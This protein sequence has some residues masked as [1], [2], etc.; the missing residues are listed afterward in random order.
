MGIARS[1]QKYR[2]HGD[3]LLKKRDALETLLLNSELL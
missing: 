1:G 2:M 3:A